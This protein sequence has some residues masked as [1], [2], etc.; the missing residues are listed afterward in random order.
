MAN[1]E[2]IKFIRGGQRICSI[3][4]YAN[5]N[6]CDKIDVRFAKTVMA[7]DHKGPGSSVQT[8]TCIIEIWE[9]EKD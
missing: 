5:Y 9:M 7:R 3:P 2:N 1:K 8:S 4:V 6:V